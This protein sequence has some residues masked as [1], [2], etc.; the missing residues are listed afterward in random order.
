MALNLP[1]GNTTFATFANGDSI[2]ASL[3][4][5]DAFMETIQKLSKA[6]SDYNRENTIV[7]YPAADV[8][9]NDAAGTMDFNISSPY[10]ISA[11][12]AR[13]CND[14]IAAYTDWIVPT[15]GELTGVK[16]LL[17]AYFY[18]VSVFTYIGD[19][20]RASVLYNDIRGLVTLDDNRTNSEFISAVT[21]PYNTI[22]TILGVITKVAVDYAAAL[23]KQEGLV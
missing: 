2:I 3:T 23:D 13:E 4:R 6:I 22:V 16:S 19:K 7:P 10:S 14:Y 1:A 15:T 11:L 12:G 20:L 5:C 9:F 17:D 21:F 8:T 18:Q